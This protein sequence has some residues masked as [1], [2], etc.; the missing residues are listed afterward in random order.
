MPLH[1]THL[2]S[3]FDVPLDTRMEFVDPRD[4]GLAFARA[5][6]EPAAEG[7]TLLVGGGERCQFIYRD[8]VRTI[9]DA[10]GVG[11]LSVEAF[12]VA[13]FYTDWLD[14]TESQRLLRYQR[15][16]LAD[17]ARV[18]RRKLGLGWMLAAAFRPLVQRWL[19]GQ[20]PYWR[21]AHGG[22]PLVTTARPLPRPVPS[23]GD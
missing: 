12:G 20:S 5:V 18:M 14:T 10:A 7:K 13:P 15:H 3:M 8:M 23:S 21:Q 2:T 16:D 6:S 19:L 11:M 17:Y 22:A 9:L 1:I 4:A